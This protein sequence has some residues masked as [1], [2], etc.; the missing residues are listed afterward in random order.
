MRADGLH[1]V[2]LSCYIY[3]GCVRAMAGVKKEVSEEGDEGDYKK[4][5]RKYD[6]SQTSLFLR[7]QDECPVGRLY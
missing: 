7:I 6:G 3:G 4:D 2:F 5:T 1:G